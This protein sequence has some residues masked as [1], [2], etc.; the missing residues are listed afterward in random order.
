MDVSKTASPDVKVPEPDTAEEICELLKQ[1]MLKYF[2]QE[3]GNG[4]RPRSAVPLV[5]QQPKDP[6]LERKRWSPMVAP[7][8]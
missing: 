4:G 2:P 1:T 6:A 7:E 5:A 3:G 8:K